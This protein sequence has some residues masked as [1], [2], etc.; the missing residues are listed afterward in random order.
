[1]KGEMGIEFTDA[2]ETKMKLGD[3]LK[4]WA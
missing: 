4:T 3:G 1:M 2:G